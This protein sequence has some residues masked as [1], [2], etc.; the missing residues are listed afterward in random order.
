MDERNVNTSPTSNNEKVMPPQLGEAS[1]IF[2]K[3]S[4]PKFLYIDNDLLLQAFPKEIIMETLK[5]SELPNQ[6]RFELTSIVPM[7]NEATDHCNKEI[8]NLNRFVI[9]PKG[10]HIPPGAE[11][12]IEIQEKIIKGEIALNKIPQDVLEK[13]IVKNLTED[14]FIKPQKGDKLDWLSFMIPDGKVFLYTILGDNVLSG[15]GLPIG[16]YTK[17][18][19]DVDPGSIKHVH[20]IDP[21]Q[22]GFT[23]GI[24]FEVYEGPGHLGPGGINGII[25]EESKPIIIINTNKKEAYF[26]NVSESKKG[27]GRKDL[28]T[29]VV[30][31]VG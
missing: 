28:M 26:V 29:S 30:N 18:D 25:V 13:I 19:E 4:Q 16:L 21:R 9:S 23:K 14:D 15:Y 8:R 20:Y 17:G 11:I 2:R 22:K 24:Y 7:F 5:L 10:F 12:D 1:K 27:F 31:V 6:L 3:L